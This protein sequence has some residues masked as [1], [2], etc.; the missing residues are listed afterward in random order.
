M[1][2][3]KLEI[4]QKDEIIKHFSMDFDSTTEEI[5]KLEKRLGMKE[6]EAEKWKKIIEQADKLATA[7]KI[8][9]EKVDKISKELKGKEKL[10]TEYEQEIEKLDYV[11]T[12]RESKL[13]KMNE[14]IMELTKKE[15]E[16]I[17]VRSK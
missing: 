4:T 14:L 1:D 17:T 2:T 6:K 11:I 7:D 16:G 3:Q 8:C 5:I 9:K 15:K 10:I 13:N 12:T